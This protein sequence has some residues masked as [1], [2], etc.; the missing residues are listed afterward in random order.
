VHIWYIAFEKVKRDF[1]LDYKPAFTVMCVSIIHISVWMQV[2]I[3]IYN[4]PK[5]FY[6]FF[7]INNVLL[8]IL[9]IN[10]S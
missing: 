7:L 9:L 10:E 4:V 5:K 8:N 2:K 6:F 1:V 3:G